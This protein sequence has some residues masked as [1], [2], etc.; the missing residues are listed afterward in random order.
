[1]KYKHIVDKLNISYKIPNIPGKKYFINDNGG[2]P[3]LVIVDQIIWVFK[4]HIRED[5]YE[6][7]ELL[8]KI[9]KYQKIFIGKDPTSKILNGNSVLIQLSDHNYIYIGE[10]IYKFKTKDII[11]KY[12]S[13]VGNSDV[14]YP[15]AIGTSNTYMMLEMSYIKNTD[16]PKNLEK[17]KKTCYPL[18]V[19]CFY[20]DKIKKPISK[21]NYKIIQERNN[22]GL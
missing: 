16:I 5:T 20:Y 13:P 14:P 9:K 22:Y 17:Y 10:K 11:I 3:F 19:Y 21:I 4:S 12:K 8:F 6:F 2:R 7:G 18:S 15:Y 1:M